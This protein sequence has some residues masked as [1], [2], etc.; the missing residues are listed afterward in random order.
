MWQTVQFKVLQLSKI[1]LFPYNKLVFVPFKQ[2]NTF[3]S[4]LRDH[5]EESLRWRKWMLNNVEYFLL[6][7][8]VTNSG[9]RFHFWLLIQH[10]LYHINCQEDESIIHLGVLCIFIMLLN[11]I[12]QTPI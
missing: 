4:F 11:K 5:L 3:Y 8:I 7:D 2:L 6:P 12:L 10:E 1:S 9:L